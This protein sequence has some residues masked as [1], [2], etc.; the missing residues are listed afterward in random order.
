[1][2]VELTRA[3]A[4]ATIDTNG[5]VVSQYAAAG[6]AILFPRQTIDGKMRGGSHVCAPYFG[7]GARPDQPQHGYAREVEWTIKEQSLGAV[8][9]HHCQTEGEY[10]GLDME[11]RYALEEDALEMQLTAHNASSK[12]MRL[13]PG[14]HPYFSCEQPID[15]I[16]VNGEA[17]ES[18]ALADTVYRGFEDG[19]IRGEVAGNTYQVTTDS[20]HE[21]AFWTAHPDRYICLEPTLA[22]NS[23]SEQQE[24]AA[25]EY[26]APGDRRQYGCHIAR[27]S[28]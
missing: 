23:F 8:V 7:P 13:T 24:G 12:T 26:I 3:Q 18:V 21:F 17:Y 5:G 15:A 2:K 4:R 10:A 6:E 9:L 27:V 28:S 19:T 22:G 25:K 11:L 20:L 14:F 16:V 1:M